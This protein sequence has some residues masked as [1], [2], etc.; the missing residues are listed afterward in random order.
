MRTAFPDIK[1][2]AIEPK[3]SPLLSEGKAGPHKIQGIGANFV[4]EVLDRTC[5]DEIYLAEH[6]KAVETVRTLAR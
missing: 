4:P 3:D 1:I 2:V 5:Y 6:P